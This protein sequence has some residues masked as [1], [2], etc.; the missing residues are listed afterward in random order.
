MQHFYKYGCDHN[1]RHLIYAKVEWEC[2]TEGQPIGQYCNK[3]LNRGFSALRES[4]FFWLNRR[5]RVSKD[6]CA[7][8][9]TSY[10]PKP[11]KFVLTFNNY[12]FCQQV[13]QPIPKIDTIV[14]KEET[15][16]L[17]EW[18]RGLKQG[19]KATFPDLKQLQLHHGYMIDRYG[20]DLLAII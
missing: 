14:I 9:T 2:E 15:T 3:C 10:F 1:G 4:V 17:M 11:W 20:A 16:P 13:G 12:T 19:L 6:V 18:L 8:I 7:L 5:C